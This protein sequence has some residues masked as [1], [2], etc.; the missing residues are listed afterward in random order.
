MTGDDQELI[1]R[2]EALAHEQHEL[3]DKESHG[4][5][6]RRDRAR[7]S[8]NASGPGAAPAFAWSGIRGALPQ[9]LAAAGVD[10]AE[11]EQVIITHVHD[12]HLGWTTVET[13]EDPMFPPAPYV[14]HRPAWE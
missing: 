7:A 1:D 14:V 8:E 3:F 12:D 6:S 4:E 9:E 2:I 13:A 11:I 5:A 10:V